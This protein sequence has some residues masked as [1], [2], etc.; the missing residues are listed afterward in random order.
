MTLLAW[1][2]SLRRPQPITASEIRSEW[3]ALKQQHAVTLQL[4]DMLALDAVND[5]TAAARWGLLDETGHELARRLQVIAAA[6]PV[7][8]AREA[9]AD[10]QSVERA[11]QRRMQDF[12]RRRQ[13]AQHFID[14]V[15]ASLPSGEVLTQ[16]RDLRDALRTEA[17]GLR[18]WSN[19]V[20]VRRP[21]DPL[22]AIHA[23][24]HL[25]VQRIEQRRWIG[26]RP[27]TLT[28]KRAASR[29]TDA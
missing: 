13:E 19:D 9:E 6:L 14:A 5:E 16:A 24:L 27:I 17:N 11:R 15:L 22:D 12:E 1:L 29:G 4:R 25:R 10:R 18:A 21:L 20:R 3:H 26:A 2:S 28:D 8:E 7:A 23:A